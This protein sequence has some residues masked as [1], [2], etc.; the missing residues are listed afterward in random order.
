VALLDLFL[1]G[2]DHWSLNPGPRTQ[3]LYQPLTGSFLSF[4]D[5]RTY[6][7]RKVLLPFMPEEELLIIQ[8]LNKCMGGSP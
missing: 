6:N 7:S 5:L 8:C 4:S 3:A 2:G 1:G